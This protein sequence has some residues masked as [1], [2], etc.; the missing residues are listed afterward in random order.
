M[1][2]T[3]S[4]KL[5]EISRYILRWIY[6]LVLSYS[7]FG[8]KLAKANALLCEIRHYVNEATIKSMYYAIF[9]PHIMLFFSV[10]TALG[11]NL[12]PK[13][14]INLLQ[15]KA[16]RTI[17]FACYVAWTLTI[18]GNLNIIKFSDLVSLCNWLSIYKHFI[19]N[20]HSVFSHVFFLASNTHEQNTRF[21]SHGL[22]TK[23]TCIENMVLMLLLL[24][25]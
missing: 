24:L 25:L 16:M 2:K 3:P 12:K 13:H 21:A 22:L 20:F 7:P 10:C 9:H 15:K 14:R 4:I 6:R 1:G 11:Q 18:F 19:S 5:C 8:P 23:P 17:S